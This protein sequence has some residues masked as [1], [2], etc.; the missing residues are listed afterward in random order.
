LTF[1]DIKSIM[2]AQV[3]R[4]REK[5]YEFKNKNMSKET[6]VDKDFL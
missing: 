6:N 5:V 2:I 4:S 1:L 3:K